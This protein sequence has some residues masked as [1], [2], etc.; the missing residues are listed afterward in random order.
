MMRN[1]SE[2]D[3]ELVSLHES[4]VSNYPRFEQ[5]SDYEQVPEQPVLSSAAQQAIHQYSV[6][7]KLPQHIYQTVHHEPSKHQQIPGK[8]VTCSG[9]TAA[10]HELNVQTIFGDNHEVRM[11]HSEPNFQ[12]DFEDKQVEPGSKK[13]L[14][15]AGHLMQQVGSAP[16]SFPLR[17]RQ[18]PHESYETSQHQ[19]VQVQCCEEVDGNYW[20]HPGIPYQSEKTHDTV[21]EELSRRI[22]S[23]VIHHQV[24]KGRHGYQEQQMYLQR[25]AVD[26]HDINT[27]RAIPR[28]QGQV[29]RNQIPEAVAPWKSSLLPQAACP[30]APHQRQ[31]SQGVQQRQQFPSHS[32]QVMSQEEDELLQRKQPAELMEDEMRAMRYIYLVNEQRIAKRLLAQS[33]RKNQKP[34]TQPANLMCMF[35]LPPML[36]EPTAIPE[37][38]SRR[39]MQE[40]ILPPYYHAQFAV[41]NG[42]CVSPLDPESEK[43]DEILTLR[44]V[45]DI[46]LLEP[47]TALPVLLQTQ[48]NTSERGNEKLT[49]RVHRRVDPESTEDRLSR[50]CHPGSRSYRNENFLQSEADHPAVRRNRGA[51]QTEQSLLCL[52]HSYDVLLTCQALLGQGFQ[53][54]K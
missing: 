49:S 53:I 5:Q 44:E 54:V 6:G 41:R 21:R 40:P 30:V 29:P 35:E 1:Y 16:Y 12:R 24:S 26:Q 7:G 36:M 45:M 10:Y 4:S 11:Q 52:F 9:S 42:P 20:C 22:P 43:C 8:C 3:E 31:E 13:P 34:L 27:T 18:K 28:E 47:P 51:L 48:S 33:D 46:E 17:S 38:V 32:M 14:V 25:P 19:N 39:R 2:D 37:G 23:E 50:Q 15:S